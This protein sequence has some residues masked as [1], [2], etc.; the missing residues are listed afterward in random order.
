ML[1]A[2]FFR[3]FDMPLLM[4]RVVFVHHFDAFAALSFTRVTR[5]DIR[6]TACFRCRH[7]FR[8][9]SILRYYFA[10]DTATLRL[11]RHVAML[12]V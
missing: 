4:L 3:D 7:I 2:D 5:Y 9:C 6:H 8:C 12:A 11:R 1:A 10:D